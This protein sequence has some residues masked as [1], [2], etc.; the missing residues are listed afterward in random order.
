[1]KEESLWGQRNALTDRWK[2]IASEPA[3]ALVTGWT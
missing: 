2:C 3:S 1:M